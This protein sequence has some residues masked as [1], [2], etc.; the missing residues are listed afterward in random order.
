MH[1]ELVKVR[2][3]E[4]TDA[5]ARQGEQVRAPDPTQTSNGNAGVAQL[6]LLGQ[7]D[8]SDVARVGAGVVE[9]AQ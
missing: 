2:N 5:Q 6:V 4:L 3:I 9:A 1:T 8:P 7:R